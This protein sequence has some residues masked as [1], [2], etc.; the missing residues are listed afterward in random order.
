MTNS[1]EFE[2]E[3]NALLNELD[4]MEQQNYMKL[5]IC[6]EKVFIIFENRTNIDMDGTKNTRKLM[7]QITEPMTVALLAN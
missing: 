1:I 6:L 2:C 7:K 4:G 5:C 3:R